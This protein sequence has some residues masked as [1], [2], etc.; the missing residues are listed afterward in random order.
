MDLASLVVVA[1]KLNGL[2]WAVFEQFETLV[3]AGD[4]DQMQAELESGRLN[5]N[6]VRLIANTLKDIRT[7]GD[8]ELAESIEDLLDEIDNFL[9]DV[10]ADAN[11]DDDDDD[12]DEDQ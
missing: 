7:S 9:S 5:V 6:A 10:Y 12:D 4:S 8:A 2:G 11:D 1:K 3:D